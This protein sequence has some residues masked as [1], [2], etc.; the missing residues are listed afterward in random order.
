MMNF[1]LVYQLNPG[2]VVVL[3]RGRIASAYLQWMLHSIALKAH[4]YFLG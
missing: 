3:H 4:H 2:D 1:A